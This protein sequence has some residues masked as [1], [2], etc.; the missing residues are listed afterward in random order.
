VTERLDDAARRVIRLAQDEAGDL[1]H[2][3]VGTEHLLLG[4]LQEGESVAARDLVR[5]GIS[6]T[7]VRDLVK[8]TIG[9]GEEAP[10]GRLPFTPRAK[11]VL[12]LSLRKARR[13]G[14]ERARPE[15]LLLGILREGEGAAVQVLVE[16]GADLDGIFDQMTMHAAQGAR[17]SD[18]PQEGPVGDVVYGVQDALRQVSGAL[19]RIVRRLGGR[20]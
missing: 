18:S 13:L 19:E 2:H 16:L 7:A 8:E 15:H 11:K 10:A 20:G 1:N 9:R 5:R 12:E 3:Y 6:L 4:L 14:L 17:E